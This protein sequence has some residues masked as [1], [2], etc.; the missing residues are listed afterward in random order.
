FFALRLPPG[1]PPLFSSA[2]SGVYEGRGG[3]LGELESVVHRIRELA[4]QAAND[5]N[6]EMDRDAIQGEVDTLIDQFDTIAYNTEFNKITLLT[7]DFAAEDDNATTVSDSEII[8]GLLAGTYKSDYATKSYVINGNTYTADQLN[9]AMVS[10]SNVAIAIQIGSYASSYGSYDSQIVNLAKKSVDNALELASQSTA[11]N[12]SFTGYLQSAA[13]KLNNSDKFGA[14]SDLA[15]ASATISDTTLKSAADTALAATQ[16]TTASAADIGTAVANTLNDATTL[17]NTLASGLISTTFSSTSTLTDVA[18]AYKE[19][20]AA[21]AAADVTAGV[22]PGIHLQVGANQ[23]QSMVVNIANATASGMRLIGAKVGSY[24]E[25]NQTITVC[26]YAIERL[27]RNRSSL[28]AYQNRLEFTASN[29]LNQSENLQ[30]S[31]SRIRDVDM[32]DEMVNYAKNN[33]LVQA[34]QS[35]MAQANSTTKGIVDLLQ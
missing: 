3:A 18:T 32:A 24:A 30:A 26:D 10:L 5:T 20:M 11:S 28:G 29:N 17:S 33:I 8:T 1:A 15:V 19:I 25:A 22:T 9:S 6:Q 13:S 16:A 7:G 14:Q 12:S 35:M 21:M 34:G 23:G 4:V 31:E 2:A 27:S